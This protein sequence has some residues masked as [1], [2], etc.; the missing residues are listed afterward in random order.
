MRPEELHFCVLSTST[1]LL[2][3]VFLWPHY[4]V[5]WYMRQAAERC[6][7]KAQELERSFQTPEGSDAAL[8]WLN[9]DRK[10]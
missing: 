5:G 8:C 10:K 6:F 2:L 9:T 4:L 1:K 3:P 7:K